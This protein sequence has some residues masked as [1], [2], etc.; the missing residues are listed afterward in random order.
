MPGRI[1]MP[2]L[3]PTQLRKQSEK[4]LKQG[5][6]EGP[7]AG[8]VPDKPHPV[9]VPWLISLYGFRVPVLEVERKHG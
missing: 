6:C 2:E 9:G 5:E 1:E 4:H 8:E 3:R 7:L